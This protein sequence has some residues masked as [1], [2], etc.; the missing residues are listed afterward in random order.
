MITIAS[1]MTSLMV[2]CSSFIRAQIKE[3]IKAPRHWPLCREFTGTGEFPAQRASN[4]ENVS[5]WWP[6][7][8]HSSKSSTHPWSQIS[9]HLPSVNTMMIQLSK[10]DVSWVMSSNL[11]IAFH[12]LN[13]QHYWQFCLLVLV[14][15]SGYI[16]YMCIMYTIYLSSAPHPPSTCCMF[17]LPV[18]T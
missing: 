9:W 15:L 16:I 4:V 18:L 1:Q 17:A 3:N 10:Y 5:I 6:H 7:L 2:V 13:Q 8:G 14:V 11:H 12:P